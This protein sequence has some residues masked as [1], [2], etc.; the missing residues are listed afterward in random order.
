MKKE[1]AGSIFA[2]LIVTLGAYLIISFAEMSF[3]PSGWHFVSR[4]LLA[5]F[6]TYSIVTV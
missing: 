5:I 2:V 3:A 1:T 4:L 6:I